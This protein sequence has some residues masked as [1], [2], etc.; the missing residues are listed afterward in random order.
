VHAHH[1]VV[2]FPETPQPLPRG[3]DGVVTT[4]AR[5]GFVHTADRIFMG[6]FTRDDALAL[7]SYT[8]LIPLD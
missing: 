3:G 2:D 4:L 8:C 1:T 6:V 7:V 5:S